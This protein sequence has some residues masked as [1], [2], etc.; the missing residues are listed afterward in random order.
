MR[1]LTLPQSRYSILGHIPIKVK[2]TYRAHGR[3]TV[4]YAHKKKEKKKNLIKCTLSFFP[5][6]NMCIHD[7][8]KS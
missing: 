1:K 7:C 6:K 2:Y 5:V 8:N 4:Q 3:T